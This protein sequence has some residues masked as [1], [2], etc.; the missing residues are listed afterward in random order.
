MTCTNARSS[1]RIRDKVIGKHGKTKKSQYIGNAYKLQSNGNAYNGNDGDG[2][3]RRDND[4]D[5]RQ[6]IRL[7]A[8]RIA[9]MKLV[10][11]IVC[12]IDNILNQGNKENM[13][14][15]LHRICVSKLKTYMREK[16]IRPINL[17]LRKYDLIRKII[18]FNKNNRT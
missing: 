12:E 15:Q 16:D 11:D 5:S 7:I 2:D 13:T 8:D 10:D 3:E 14:I 1:K 17:Y 9:R 18:K 6:D 4:G